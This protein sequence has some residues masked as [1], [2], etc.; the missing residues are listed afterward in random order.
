MRNECVQMS[1][2][3]TY[4]QVSRSERED[5]PKFF[6]LL[7]EHIDWKSLVPARFYLA[8]YRRLGRKRKYKLESFL[9][10]LVLQRVFGY[11]HKRSWDCSTYRAF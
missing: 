6:R 2:F 10:A 4:C 5:Q 9:K 11:R 1:L 8:F 3:D 7:N